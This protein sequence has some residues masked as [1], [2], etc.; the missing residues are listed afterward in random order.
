[1]RRLLASSHGF[2][3]LSVQNALRTLIEALTKKW[4]TTPP[5]GLACFVGQTSEG[6]ESLSFE[7]SLPILR[8]RYF[9]DK[10][11]HVEDLKAME[12]KK[13]TVG[14]VTLDGKGA[15]LALS[16]GDWLTVVGSKSI[17]LSSSTR[18]GGQS[19]PRITRLHMES[20]ENG[21][22]DVS[23]EVKKELLPFTSLFIL[24]GPAEMKVLLKEKLLGLS[25]SSPIQVETLDLSSTSMDDLHERSED[26]LKRM[27]AQKWETI[28]GQW[29]TILERHPDSLLIGGKEVKEGVKMSLAKEVLIGEGHPRF[30][31]I[32]ETC[33]AFGTLLTEVPSTF[34]YRFP[35]LAEAS[36][37]G[38]RRF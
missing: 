13:P 20:V 26:I 21:I 5:N 19:A 10:V 31:T 28:F 3:R 17:R 37:I 38:V 25:L 8:N 11:F 32:E 24:G 15:T 7:P 1:M 6:F 22:K 2:N 14:L 35:L 18:R 33:R 36:M 4:K 12:V 16:K 29:S 30:R 23:E 27:E 9:C 34:V